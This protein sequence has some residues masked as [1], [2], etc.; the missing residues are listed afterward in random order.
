MKKSNRRNAPPRIAI[1][2]SQMHWR[3]EDNT[4]A[5]LEDLTQAAD[6]GAHIC[7]FPELAITGFHRLIKTEAEP[8][9]IEQALRQIRALCKERSIACVVGAPTFAQ[10]NAPF[11]S[12]IHINERGEIAAVISKIGLTASEASFFAAGSCRPIAHLHQMRCT[13]VLCRE[14][15]DLEPIK[16]QLPSGA[17][18]IIF[19]PSLVGHAPSNPP[20]PSNIDYLPLA[21]QL[22]KQ[23][24]AHLIQCNWPNSLNTPDA[25]YLGESAVIS[26][27]GELLF[28]LPRNQ[29]GMAI[30][31][32]GSDQYKW[33]ER[34]PAKSNHVISIQ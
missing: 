24:A 28:Q 27:T 34:L 22:A 21:Q 30:F 2:Q 29:A 11:N 1:V 18:D 3:C 25:S 6:T 26:A 16:T 17:C 13:S 32:L 8:L 7:V 4:L 20:D 12:H 15:E 33:L 31:T 9:G 19:W 5:I 10:D 23:S 14:V